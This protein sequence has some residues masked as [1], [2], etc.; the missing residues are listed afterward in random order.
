M[1]TSSPSIWVLGVLLALGGCGGGEEEDALSA[2]EER[3]AP[4]YEENE[5]TGTSDFDESVLPDDFPRNLI[6][7]SY[8]VASYNKIGEFEG[9]AFET[10][11][12]VDDAISKYIEV[13]G[14]PAINID[15]GGDD[16]RTAQWHTTPWAVAIME[17]RG[18]AIVSFSRIAE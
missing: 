12:P 9:A 14:E 16:G 2:D 6:P 1:K 3:A 4:A 11:Q 17:D 18:G 8:D 7:E 5:S 13:L 10:E 15:A